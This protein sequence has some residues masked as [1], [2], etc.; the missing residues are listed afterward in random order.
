MNTLQSNLNDLFI[1]PISLQ[2]MQDPVINTSC[3]HTYERTQINEWI[4]AQQRIQP[5]AVF[6][7][8]VCREPITH[9]ISNI[10]LRQALEVLDA[11]DNNLEDGITAITLRREEDLLIGVPHRLPEPKRFMRKVEKAISQ[12]RQAICTF[13]KY[14]SQNSLFE[15]RH[16]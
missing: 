4:T 1:C 13:K 2:R 5:G 11:P 10:L 3:G 7:C 12:V 6:R 8:A 14:P 16:F 9:L 15:L